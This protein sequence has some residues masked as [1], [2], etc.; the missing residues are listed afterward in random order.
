MEDDKKT[1]DLRA[2]KASPECPL[3]GRRMAMAMG[4]MFVARDK[5]R[6]S[7]RE[8]PRPRPL[9]S[10]TFPGLIMM[11]CCFFSEPYSTSSRCLFLALSFFATTA[12]I[13]NVVRE[14]VDKV[15]LKANTMAKWAGESHFQGSSSRPPPSPVDYIKIKLHKKLN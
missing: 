12:K 5:I 8:V 14:I 1:L 10:P 7:Q 9:A 11:R 4:Y 6:Y 2:Q 3:T 13:F 15:C